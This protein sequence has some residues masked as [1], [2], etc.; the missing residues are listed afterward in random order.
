MERPATK[1]TQTELHCA[2]PGAGVLKEEEEES[3]EDQEEESFS[4]QDERP[5][6]SQETLKMVPETKGQEEES[7]EGSPRRSGRTRREPARYVPARGK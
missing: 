4:A 2:T 1:E 6:Q 3:P 5:Y 7:P